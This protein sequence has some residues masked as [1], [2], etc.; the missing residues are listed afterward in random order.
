MIAAASHRRAG[1]FTLVEILV[2]LVIMGLLAGMS[3]P[4]FLRMVRVS[5]F[6]A[7]GRQVIDQCNL[8]RQTSQTRGLPVEV[9]FYK[10][11]EYGTKPTDGPAVFRAFR[12]FVIEESDA[13]PLGKLV[14]FD[15]PAVFATSAPEGG[16]LVSRAAS[17]PGATDTALPYY[18]M[19]YR[20]V[21]FQFLPGGGTDLASA[22]SFVTLVMERDK[23]LHD[24]GNYATI[25]IVPGNGTIRLFH[26]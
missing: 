16:L 24:G 10:L 9:R 26:P 2:V 20:Q 17:P 21:A 13:V 6:N 12:L 18:G 7:A 4:S 15:E 1:G 14:A 25:Q 19:N 11:P 5:K 22:E 8:A 23:P 3:L